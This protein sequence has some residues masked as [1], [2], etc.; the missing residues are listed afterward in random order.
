MDPLGNMHLRS[1]EVRKSPLN[2]ASECQAKIPAGVGRDVWFPEPA[3]L[4]QVQQRSRL[5]SS[6]S[7]AH[8]I[9]TPETSNF[10][11]VVGREAVA[12]LRA[13]GLV[14]GGHSVAGLR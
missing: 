13:A 2:E 12:I 4:L 10:A 5:M 9:P 7:K 14:F 11:R 3:K 1:R 6:Q 8:R